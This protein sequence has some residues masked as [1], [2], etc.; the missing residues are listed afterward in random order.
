MRTLTRLLLG[1]TLWALLAAGTPAIAGPLDGS[2]AQKAL[3]CSACHG[4]AGNSRGD[5][6]PILAGADAAYLKKALSDYAAGRRPS[7]EM[8]PYAKMAQHFGVD[9]IAA[10][11]ASQP[12]QATPVKVSRSSCANFM[13]MSGTS[14]PGCVMRTPTS[15]T[16]TGTSG[17]LTASSG[18]S[19]V[20][21]ET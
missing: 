19:M 5:T 14:M 20:T 12:R 7:P 13:L 21:N 11:F 15:V 6:V 16:S 10:Y 9:D 17:M 2:G 1:T 18:I 8:E 4:F 3:V